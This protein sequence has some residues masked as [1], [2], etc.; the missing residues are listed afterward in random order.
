MTCSCVDRPLRRAILSYQNFVKVSFNANKL[1][2]NYS[3]CE[4]NSA[5]CVKVFQRE[6]SAQ[7][8]FHGK[9]APQNSMLTIL[10]ICRHV[11]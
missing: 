11:K 1:K 3:P 2:L 7:F 5:D 8:H 4:F 9:D 6:F 10:M